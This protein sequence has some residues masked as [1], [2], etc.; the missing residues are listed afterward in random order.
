MKHLQGEWFR[1]YDKAKA[2]V[3]PP[4]PAPVR[5]PAPKEPAPDV[6]KA[7]ADHKMADEVADMLEKGVPFNSVT[8]QSRANRIYGGGLA[9]GAYSRDRLYDAIELGVNRYIQRHP[10]EFST[11]ANVGEAMQTAKKL[12]ALKDSLPTQT[13]RAGE[14]D[15]YQQFSTPPDYAYAAAWVANLKAG[16]H[17]LE[18]SAG[19]GGLIVHA[20]TSGVRETTVNELSD[21]RRGMIAALEPTRVTGEDAAQLHNILPPDIRPTVVIMN[22]PFSRAAERMGGK[23]VADEGAKH[24]EQALQRLEPGGRLVAIVGDGMKPEGTAAVGTARQGTGR[25]FRDWWAKIGREYDVLANVGVDR[26]IYTKYGTSFPTR[27]LVIDK[28]PPSGRE[29]VTG[30]VKDAAGLIEHLQEVRNDRGTSEQAAGRA[31]GPGV[32][33]EGEGVARPRSELPTA[34]GGLG[35]RE[36]AGGRAGAEVAEPAGAPRR[37]AGG[38]GAAGSAVGGEGRPVVPVEPQPGRG[39]AVSDAG[40]GTAVGGEPGGRSADRGADGIRP[41]G[42]GE[43]EQPGVTPAPEDVLATEDAVTKPDDTGIT[44]AIYETY[45]PQRVQI[46]GAKA[47]PGALV[48]SAAMASVLPPK[49]DYKPRI[50]ASLV[51]SGALSDAQLEAI[52]YAGHAHSDVMANGKRRGFFI[53]DGTGV[54]KGREIAGIFLDNKQNGRTKGV[55]VSE[56]R[57]LLNDAQR[58]WNGLLQPKDEIIDHGKT[59][60]GDEITAKKGILFTTYDTMKSAEQTKTDGEKV[61]GKE[62]VDQIVEWL[63]KDFDGV[64]AFDESHN[65]G[66]AVDEKGA[67]GVKKAA[68]KALAGIAL[69]EKLPNARVVYVSATG[70]TE[71]GNLAYADRLGLWGEGTPFPNRNDFVSKVQ[72]GGMAAMELVARDMKALGHYIARSLSYDGVSYDRVEH[73]LNPDQRVTYD[74][75]AEGWQKVLQ[76]FNAALEMTGVTEEGKTL[77]AKQKSAMLSAFWGGHQRFFNQI[78]TS[79]QMPSVIKGVEADVKAGRQ[80]VLQLVN[81]MEAAQERALEKARKG[82]G[83]L[84]DLDMTPRDQLIQLVEKSFPV[85]Q[86]E[87]YV[88]ENNNVRSRAVQDSSGNAVL[89][90]EA[91]AARERLIDE[92]GSIRVP[93]GPL[94]MLMNHFGAENV[95]EVTGRGQRVVKKPDETGRITTQVEKRGAQSNVADAADFQAGKKKILVFSEAGGTGRSYHAAIDSGSEDARRSHYLVQGG[96]RADKAV[97]GFGRTHRTSQASAPIFHLVTTDLQGQKRF[98]SSIARRLGQLGALTKGERRTGDQ[99]LFGMRDNLES[100]EARD[101]LRQ[102]FRDVMSDKV[103]GVTT[104]DLEEGMGLKLRDPSTGGEVKELPEMSQFLNR[105][106]SLKIDQQNRVFDAF[107]ERM[108]QAID[109][110]AAAGTLDTGV[111]AYK[112]DKITKVSEQTVF[113]D[114]RSGAETMHVHLQA[115]TLN[116][117]VD[118]DATLAGRNKTGG[119]KPEGFIVNEQSGN[120]FAVTSGNDRT[121][122]NGTIVAQVRLTG[123]TDYQYVDRYKVSQGN[124][125]KVTAEEARP[126]WDDQFNAVP[127]YRKSDLHLITGAVLPIWDR[128]GGSPKIYRLQTDTNERML[129]RVIPSSMVDATLDRLGAEARKMTDTPAEIAQRIL[130]GDTAMLANDWKIMSRWVAGENRLELIGPDYRHFE[131][132]KRHGIFSERIDYKTRFFIPTEPAAAASA[133]EAITKTRPVV[134]LDDGS[135]AKFSPRKLT[136]PAGPA[137]METREASADELASRERQVDK[138]RAQLQMKGKATRGGQEAA[139]DLPLFG[140]DRQG[141]LFSPRRTPEQE[142]TIEKV[143]A[144]EKPGFVEQLKAAREDWRRKTLRNVLD[145]YIGLKDEQPENYVAARMANSTHAAQAGLLELGTLKFDGDTYAMKDRNGGVQD[146]VAR[147]LHHEAGDFLKWVAGNRAEKLAGEGR[148]NLMSQEDIKNL[149]SL[150]QGTLDFDYELSNGKTTRS[151]EAAFLDSLKKYHEFNSNVIDLNVEAG[152]ISRKQGAELKADPFYVPFFRVPDEAGRDFVGPSLSSGL[153]KQSAFKKLMGGTEQL[154]KDLWE[155]AISNW[156]HMVDAALRNKTAAKIADTSVKLGAAREMTLQEVNHL[157]DKE[158][159]A[160]TTWVMRDGEKVYYA[161]EDPMV[162]KAVSALDSIPPGG[163]IMNT[164]RWF[165]RT[166]R[167]GV[168]SN[169]LFALR[170][171]VR[172]TQN[173]MATTHVSL[174]P[175]KNLADG[176]AQHDMGGALTNLARS[177]AGQELQAMKLDPQAADAFVG[178]GLMRLGS[179]QEGGIRRTTAANILDTPDKLGEFWHRISNVARAYKEVAAVGEDV[180]RLALYKQARETG[181][182]H[183]EA[184]FSARDLQDFTL[185]GAAQW[186]R[187]LGD[188]TPFLNARAQGLYKLGRVAADS[189]RSVMAAVGGKVAK[190]LTMRAAAMI[191]AMAVADLA[192]QA[193]YA[194]DPDYKKRTEDDLNMNWW[195]KVGDTQFRIPKGF[196]MSAISRLLSSGAEVFFNPEMTGERW[197][198]NLWNLLGQNL[199]VQLPAVLQPAYD[200]ATNTSRLGRAITPR[201]LEDLRSEQQSTGSTTLVSRGASAVAN[202]VTRGLGLGETLSPIQMDYLVQAY[203]GWSAATVLAAADRVAR[204]MSD[205]PTKP[206]GDLLATLTQGMMRNDPNPSSRYVDMLYKQGKEVE[207]AYATYRDILTRGHAA[208]AQQFF[209]DNQE[210][211]QKHG[212]VA[213]LMRLEG[214]LNKQ[215]RL[216][217]NN[218][219]STPEQKRLQILQLTAMK[220]RAAQQVFG[221]P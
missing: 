71:V 154:N 110:A 96:W 26:D 185:E 148:E 101:G 140:G 85:Q 32:A 97:Q 55:W 27:L 157:S 111:E 192:L 194:D 176:F 146:Y 182:S 137:L 142:R 49:S 113:T 60:S 212:M 69:Q 42:S 201:G 23:M 204:T 22:P 15:A 130:K 206:E 24:I 35:L 30:Q 92:L 211:L 44:E 174:N 197:V 202:T 213:G 68:Q 7:E 217:S 33:A 46:V 221:A 183:T 178:G 4:E 67:R 58:D 76:N 196:E 79:M 56:K 66:N 220:N 65:L 29:L 99:G 48:Q 63:G 141:T 147:P 45:R 175:I 94:E 209:R 218:P 39:G 207:R 115:H 125:R 216:V 109:R 10:E 169:P 122:S 19:V 162:L 180:N 72:E 98:I 144:G 54:G 2:E 91:V 127:E 161:V 62:R 70:A 80:A 87:T 89:N 43:R 93:D 179:G 195:F 83:D 105:V 38:D 18:P 41:D 25:A 73:V 163:V 143:F 177:M 173:T 166:L 64:I 160:K 103:E 164:G 102:F 5:E 107:S 31:G 123:P 128:L 6:K 20:M 40:A 210:T 208:E 152:N 100:T 199:Q 53:G 167:A 90:R 28:N 124:W 191:G 108:D 165:A 104:K 13:V 77:N 158:L 1:A 117:P 14:K 47:H 12:A 78:I 153:T 155:N 75:L 9:E 11:A 121:D 136:E 170:M 135:G 3:L 149:K 8:I 133:I 116:H 34:T 203:G 184:S 118:F 188:L 145:P 200:V 119:K 156:S 126:L 159:K 21:K 59:K 215:V 129:G 132:M 51:K 95:A 134:S 172:D 112:A 139:D 61:R 84:E 150:N 52:V 151:R 36:G 219:D 131:E 190:S 214:N 86:M 171:L 37:G 82:E 114:P 81:T 181:S 187:V 57:A 138:E 168:T 106:L 16:D 17:V 50:P 74:K 120:V 186:V 193:I 198:G 189:D 205:E 88:D